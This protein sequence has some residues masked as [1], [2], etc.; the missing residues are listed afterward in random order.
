MKT[1][2]PANALLRTATTD[3]RM[4]QC[5]GAACAIEG[6]HTWHTPG[7]CK[8]DWPWDKAHTAHLKKAARAPVVL[9]VNGRPVITRS[10]RFDGLLPTV[11]NSRGQTLH[12]DRLR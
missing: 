9:S 11:C 2:L 1:T 6:W 12:S 10:I 5:H 4:A 7:A 8:A 3:A